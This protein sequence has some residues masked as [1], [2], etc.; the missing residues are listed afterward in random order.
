MAITWILTVTG[1][2]G[3]ISM[4]WVIR[5]LPSGIHSM[6]GSVRIA[7]CMGNEFRPL[8]SNIRFLDGHGEWRTF[9]Q[10]QPRSPIHASAFG[11]GDFAY[12]CYE[13]AFR[14]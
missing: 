1:T 7:H 2:R 6:Y 12:T 8:W 9:A 5:M 11:I 3:G 13:P 10:I 14:S 4:V